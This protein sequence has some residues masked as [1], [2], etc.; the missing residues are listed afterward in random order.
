MILNLRNMKK[1]GY[2]FRC[3]APAEGEKCPRCEA[4]LYRDQRKLETRRVRRM[5]VGGVKPDR[6]AGLGPWGIVALVLVALLLTAIAVVAAS[7]AGVS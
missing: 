7:A 3:D 2:C 6:P 5:A 4:P 1:T